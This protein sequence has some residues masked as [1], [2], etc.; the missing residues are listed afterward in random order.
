MLA[1]LVLDAL[2]WSVCFFPVG[3]GTLICEVKSYV[4]FVLF[5][6]SQTKLRHEL[7]FET[8]KLISVRDSERTPHIP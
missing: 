7:N 1:L 8:E 5:L 6:S 2:S 3:Y 4:K